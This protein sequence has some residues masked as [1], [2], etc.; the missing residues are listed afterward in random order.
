MGVRAKIL[1]RLIELHAGG[2]LP[3]GAAVVEL[4]A[5]QLQLKGVES[6]VRN[7]I[8][9]FAAVDPRLRPLADYS[10]GEIARLAA[11]GY[12]GEL[13][14]A[15]GFDYSAI[16]LFQAYK[17]ILLDLNL[18]Q[19][20]PELAGHFDLVTNFGTTEHLINQ[21]L[22]MKNIHDLARPGGLIHHDLPLA[23]YYDH[24]YFC[25]TP[26]FFHDLAEAN[27]YEIVAEA[28][29]KDSTAA[30]VPGYMRKNGFPDAAFNDLG[31]EFVLRK[32]GDAPFRLPLDPI[33]SLAIDGSVWREAGSA[34]IAYSSAQATALDR[35]PGRDLQRALIARYWKKATR[36][37]GG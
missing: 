9:H 31:V 14:T 30:A 36:W 20:P 11:G 19:I 7:F 17:T 37:F 1:V 23:G 22:A 15:C 24:G 32:T 12:V 34:Q 3:S 10:K 16:D 27:G 28:Y 4:G 35:V 5:Q 33:T 6:V 18:H 21:F 8:A 2:M 26:R 25:Y 29:S 13:M